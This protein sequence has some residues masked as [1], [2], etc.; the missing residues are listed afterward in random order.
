MA[1][2]LALLT[3]S[4]LECLLQLA[5]ACEIDIP[6]AAL[7]NDRGSQ[8]ISAHLDYMGGATQSTE[9][10][11]LLNRYIELARKKDEEK[12]MVGKEMKVREFEGANNKKVASGLSG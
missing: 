10:A 2:K 11:V 12:E 4:A 1:E 3:P 8:P 7:V 9:V 6:S 5:S